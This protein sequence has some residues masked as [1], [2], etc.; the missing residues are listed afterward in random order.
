MRGYSEIREWFNDSKK[1]YPHRSV[2][3]RVGWE[4]ICGKL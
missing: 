3:R 1:N 2:R 4:N